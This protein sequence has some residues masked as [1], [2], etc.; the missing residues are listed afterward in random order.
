MQP[1]LVARRTAGLLLPRRPTMSSRKG[2]DDCAAM[3]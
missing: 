3:V 2:H 1:S